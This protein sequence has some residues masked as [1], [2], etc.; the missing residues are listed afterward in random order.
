M[1]FGYLD[2]TPKVNKRQPHKRKSEKITKKET[3]KAVFERFIEFKQKQNLRATTLNQHLLLYNNVENFHYTRTYRPFYL[4]DI[5]T[6][7]ISNYCYWLKNEAIRFDGHKYKPDSTQTQGLADASINGRIKY[8]KTFVNWC[9]KQDLLSKN[10]FDMWEG[11]KRDAHNIDILT[12]DELKRLL[13]VAKE[14]SK[15]SYK[16]VRDYVLLHVLIDGMF[17]ISE[18][19]LISSS[20]IDEMNKTL[21]IRSKHAKSRKARIVPLSNKTFRLIMQLIEENKAFE[22]DVDDLIFLSLSGRMLSKNNCLRDFKKLA[23]EANIK[24]RFYLHLIRHSVATHYLESGDVESLR[25]ILGHSD[26][27]TVLT[28][29]HIADNTII[30]KHANAGFF[31]NDNITS[32]K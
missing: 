29:A 3:A 11:F 25:K 19:L 20:D 32:R 23:K 2:E 26:L 31:G 14:H 5:T 28:Y 24:K 27:R 22:G 13:K 7:F 18:A 12:R 6:D 21:I 8:L 16:H 17:R 9:V 4:T 10:P 1:S 30:E 15:N